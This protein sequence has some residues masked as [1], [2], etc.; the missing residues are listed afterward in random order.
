MQH[1]KNNQN[2]NQILVQWGYGCPVVSSVA[3]FGEILPK[4]QKIWQFCEVL[5]S[6]L[7]NFE[8]ALEISYAIG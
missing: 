3:R 5:F 2:I 6:T 7:Q 1:I 8:A 4:G